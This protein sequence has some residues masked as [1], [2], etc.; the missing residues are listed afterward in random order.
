MIDLYKYISEGLLRGMDD[1]LAT[2]ESDADYLR[3]K[4]WLEYTKS[5]GFVSADLDNCMRK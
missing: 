1:T 4:E 3:I 2:G 5:K